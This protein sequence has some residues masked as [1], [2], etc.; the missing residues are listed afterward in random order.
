MLPGFS[1]RFDCE[2][3]SVFLLL[4]RSALSVFH[5]ERVYLPA[6]LLWSTERAGCSAA[7]CKPLRRFH[8]PATLHNFRRHSECVTLA[9]PLL[10]ATVRVKRWPLSHTRGCAASLVLPSPAR[11]SRYLKF[12]SVLCRPF[13][14]SVKNRTNLKPLAKFCQRNRLA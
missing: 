3:R 11:C 9:P 6:R 10:L 7:G 2:H 4:W 13:S 1:H 12:P 5:K 14:E 8:P